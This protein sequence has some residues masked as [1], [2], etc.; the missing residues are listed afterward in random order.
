MSPPSWE[1]APVFQGSLIIYYTGSKLYVSCNIPN[2]C[3]IQYDWLVVLILLGVWVVIC[4]R[5]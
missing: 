5:D 1:L 2:L 3:C 4:Q